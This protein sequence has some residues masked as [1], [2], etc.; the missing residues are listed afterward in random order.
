MS[1]I[2]RTETLGQNVHHGGGRQKILKHGCF[3][4]G[5]NI[6]LKNKEKCR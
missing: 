2:K 4:W 3:G 5:L 6:P 1:E